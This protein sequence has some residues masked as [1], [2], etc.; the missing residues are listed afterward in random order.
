MKNILNIRLLPIYSAIVALTGCVSQDITHRVD[1][2][3]AVSSVQV[4][5]LLQK[6]KPTLSKA[7]RERAEEVNM[8]Y[9]AG[10]AVPLERSYTL[11]R[12]LQKDVKTAVMFPENRVSLSTAAERIMLATGLIV[13]ITP[14]VYIEDAMLLPKTSA[15]TS[16]TAAS[17]P[18]GAIQTFGT[19]TTPA[20]PSL[21]TSSN[22]SVAGGRTEPD[23]P[24][25][26]QF[27]KTEAPLSQIL[28][29]IAVRL[30]IKWKYD[31][32]NN[33]IKFYR[34][35]TKSWE[36]PLSASKSSYSTSFD[37]TNTATTNTNAVVA[38]PGQSP[39]KQSSQDLD[40]L[41]TLVDN[42]SSVMT[43]SG[44]VIS[45]DATGTITM[46]DTSDSVDKA[47][48]IIN[49]EMAI[50]KRQVILKLQTIQV[51]STD[52]EEASMNIS[53]VVNAALQRMPDLSFTT[54][55]PASLASTNTGTLGINILSGQANGSSAM[56]KA[57]HEIG[58]V[59]VSTEVPLTTRN[60]KAIF[61]NVTNTFSYVQSTTPAAATITGSGGTPGI[62]TA[63]DQVGLKLMMFPKVTSKDT[64]MLTMSLD[65]SVLQNIET[66]TS[67]AGSSAQSVQLPNKNAQGSE[68]EVPIHSGQTMII[69][70]F[71]QKTN[72]Y[73]KRS[74]GNGVPTILG[75]SGTAAT[76]RTTTIVLVSVL[77][78]DI[79]N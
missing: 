30:G 50:L 73:D 63:Q 72:Q 33:T 11:P 53:A 3:S 31:D 44:S 28:D 62:T 16:K 66:F 7:E 69:T 18:A 54:T 6:A 19:G 41:K 40:E 52:S 10:A 49:K 15:N 42:I 32:S 78:K 46:S 37:G 75:G 14:D 34:L 64:V 79:D 4:D 23:T 8:A 48:V 51:S 56:L 2:V 12:A 27:P 21:I 39:V 60:R 74:L 65:Q 26:F 61:Y 35:V 55:G 9:I 70:G 17:L 29:V 45:N 47:E 59:N 5:Q 68:Q 57:L 58:N 67:G 38:K 20:L 22:P 1:K 43:K 77:V 13:S 76:N 25:S 71:D 36:T 24:Y